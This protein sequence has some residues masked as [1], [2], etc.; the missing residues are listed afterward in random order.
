MKN[1]FG[2]LLLVF[3][4]AC[5]GVLLTGDLTTYQLAFIVSFGFIISPIFFLLIF[6]E[7]K[8]KPL[9]LGK[10]NLVTGKWEKKTVW[11]YVPQFIRNIIMKII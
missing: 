5:L 7:K 6:R 11:F 1:L 3:S 9:V 2:L 4:G 10:I 8:S